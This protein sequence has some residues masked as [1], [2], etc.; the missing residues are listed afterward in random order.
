MPPNTP[1]FLLGLCVG[2]VLLVMGLMLGYF[3]GRRAGVASQVVDREQFLYFLRNLSNWTSEFAGDVS[4]YQTELTSLSARVQGDSAPPREEIGSL[5]TQIMQANQQLQNRLDSAEARLESQTHQIADYLTEARTDGL[6]GLANRKAF[7]QTL[8]ELYLAWQTKKQPFSLL[9]IDIDH[10]K[11]INDTYGHP[12]G[13]TVLKK[14]SEIL[15]AE[16]RD[17]VCVARYGGEEFA[18][19]TLLPLTDTAEWLDRV[20]A[21]VARQEFVHESTRI[22]VS[23]SGGVSIIAAD[24]KPGK[25]VRRSDEALYASK[26]G[27]RNRVHLHDGTGCR[28]V[29]KTASVSNRVEHAPTPA[30]IDAQK[31]VQDRLD[32]IVEEESRRVAGVER[33]A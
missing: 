31:R 14:L 33:R 28:L 23:L 4:K 12:A 21:E 25:L 20:R 17:A 32:R 11:S 27:G 19:L 1:V 16:F 13:D 26:Q 18:V 7:D 8:D 30:Q 22:P 5:L 15:R 6:T 10:F 3:F 29:T 9:L 2:T 24:D